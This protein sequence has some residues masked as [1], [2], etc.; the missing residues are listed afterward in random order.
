MVDTKPQVRR[1]RNLEMLRHMRDVDEVIFDGQKETVRFARHSNP[2]EKKVVDG[3]VVDIPVGGFKAV[4][5]YVDE[6]AFL[7]PT[8]IVCDRAEVGYG[9]HIGIYATVLPGAIVLPETR[10]MKR[11]TVYSKMAR[12][13]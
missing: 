8:A 13:E 12:L 6:T 10:V 4:S 3:K 5:A 1:I 9:A 7:H 2:S 11:E